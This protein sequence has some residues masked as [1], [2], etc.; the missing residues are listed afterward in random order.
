MQDK[1]SIELAEY[2]HFKAVLELNNAAIPAVNAL[3]LSELE[4]LAA[5]SCYFRVACSDEQV[6][7]FL[8]M[9]AP[10]AIYKSLNYAWFS[11]KFDDFAYVDRIVIDPSI[12]GQGVGRKFYTDAVNELK[13]NFRRITCEV[14]IKPPN[15]ISLAFH[16]ALGFEEVGQQDT[17]GGTKRVTLLTKALAIE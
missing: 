8:L 2:K 5:Q 9:L 12:A 13:H 10:G 16:A 4:Q 3:D 11:K 15:P 17:E 6:L 7:G 1:I 14:N